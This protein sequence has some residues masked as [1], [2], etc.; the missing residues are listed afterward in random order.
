MDISNPGILGAKEL[1][2]PIFRGFKTW[3]MG[4]DTDYVNIV[5]NNYLSFGTAPFIKCKVSSFQGV[6]I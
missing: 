3:Y 6:M 5:Y 1:N 4:I 2:G